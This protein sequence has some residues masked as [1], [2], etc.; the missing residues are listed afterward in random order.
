MAYANIKLPLSASDGALSPA[1]LSASS[2]GVAS[3]TENLIRQLRDIGKVNMARRFEVTLSS[4]LKYTHGRDV[5]WCDFNSTLMSGYE[6]YLI[7]RGLC[8]NTS[9]FYMRNLRSIVNRAAELRGCGVPG[10]AFKHVYTGID[11]TVKRAL[12]LNA[13]RQI[14]DIDLSRSAPLEFARNVFMFSF[15]T[16]G[17]AFVDIAFLRKTDLSHGIITYKR[18][19]TRQLI[20]VRVE[21]PAMVLMRKMGQCESSRLLPIIKNDAEDA[22]RQYRNAYHCVNRNLR[23]IGERIGLPT[24]LTLYVARH[25][26]ASIAWSANIPIATISEAMGHDS[27]S[28]TR[29][30][31][32]TLD[33]SS[34]DNANSLVLAMM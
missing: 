8:R 2:Q 13:I 1:K 7:G 23:R 5:G 31:L 15:Y 24:H 25:A 33:T 21:P 32:S 10:N 20:R 19:K 16:R 22:E 30:Y 9:S 34:V 29:I 14:R 26:W 17:M 4:F 3:F 11:K 12:P 18:R 6:E 28:T 27:E